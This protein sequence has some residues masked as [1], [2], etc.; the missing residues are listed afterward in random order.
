MSC[1]HFYVYV[2]IKT[3]TCFSVEHVGR[4]SI[5]LSRC[6][7]AADYERVRMFFFSSPFADGSSFEA[8]LKLDM[9]EKAHEV[10]FASITSP[11]KNSLI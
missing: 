7:G 2:T 1:L 6:H 5:G 8:P 11:I 4:V 9:I 10:L 3:R